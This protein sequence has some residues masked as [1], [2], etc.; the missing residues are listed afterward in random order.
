MF[1]DQPKALKSIA[2]S[3]KTG[4][5]FFA[6]IETTSNPE[7][8][9]I[10]AFDEMKRDVSLIGP[11]LAMLPNPTGISRPN[12]GNL[13]IMLTQAGFTNIQS[14]IESRTCRMTKE[15][16]RKIQLPI[17]LSSPGAQML[18]NSTSDNWYAKK[19][20][21]GA[22]W[23]V[24]MSPEEK[25]EHDAPFFPESNHPLIQKIRTND[26]CRYLF[27]NFL[28][29]CLKKLHD[30]EDDTYTWNYE[31]TIIKATKK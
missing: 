4:G 5:I 17:L 11:L 3:L 21:E 6:D 25:E 22:F 15:Q 1:S 30:N 18:V 24:N 12:Y 13:H 23:W 28:R 14:K 20:G 19:A 8:D 2:N 27:N 7:P 10:I 9:G 31:M 16:F 29:R 26:F